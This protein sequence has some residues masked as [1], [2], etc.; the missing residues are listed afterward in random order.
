MSRKEPLELNGKP[1][2]VSPLT[3]GILDLLIATIK[4]L[5]EYDQATGDLEDCLLD[6]S[7]KK[8]EALDLIISKL[9]DLSI[10]EDIDIPYDFSEL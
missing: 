7:V 9:E 2:D 1:L 4:I 6:Y 10:N 5:K 8:Q 3:G